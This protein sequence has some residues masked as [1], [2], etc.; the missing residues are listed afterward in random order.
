MNFHPV[1]RGWLFFAGLGSAA[2]IGLAL[3]QPDAAPLP[4]SV[5]ALEWFALA[6]SC[7]LV[8]VAVELRTFIRN[9]NRMPFH[10]LW[11]AVYVE[12]AS[13]VTLFLTGETA[14]NAVISFA[15][16]AALAMGS[17]WYLGVIARAAV[18]SP[19]GDR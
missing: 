10:L 8:Y 16:P 17:I 6:V 9:G 5:V 2:K 11:A 18:V 3:T 13:A 4:R 15:I 1:F 19:P 14:I 7:G 12:A